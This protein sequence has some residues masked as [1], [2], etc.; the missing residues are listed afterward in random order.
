MPERE[1][2]VLMGMGGFFVLL[3]IGGIIWGRAEEK[4]YYNAISRRFD[5]REFL[6]HW[7]PRPEPGALKVGGWIAITVGLLMLIAGGVLWLR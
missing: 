3:G 1:W 6:E 4:S 7:P 5:V 2:F